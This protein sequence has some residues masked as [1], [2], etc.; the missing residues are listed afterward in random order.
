MLTDL[1]LDHNGSE[2]MIPPLRALGYAVA[3]AREVGLDAAEDDEHL[4]FAALQGRVLI[5]RDKKDYRLLHRAWRRWPAARQIDQQHSGILII[6]Q[7][8]EWQESRAADELHRFLQTAPALRNALYQYMTKTG[9]THR[10]RAS[11]T[12][13]RWRIRVRSR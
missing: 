13:E 4:L 1:Y 10:Y 6:P 12:H 7:P 5:T 11:H 9:W 3:N 8:P 2:R